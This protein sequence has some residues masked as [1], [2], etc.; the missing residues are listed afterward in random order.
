MNNTSSIVHYLHLEMAV[1]LF[2]VVHC[3]WIIVQYSCQITKWAVIEPSIS[4]AEFSV[5]RFLCSGIEWVHVSTKH[6]SLFVDWVMR[7]FAVR[8][9][10]L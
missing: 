3:D 7:Q 4:A 10:G 6:V 9:H 5:Y 2:L 1:T 8:E